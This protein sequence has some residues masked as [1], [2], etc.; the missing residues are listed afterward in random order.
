MQSRL[1][2]GIREFRSAE[3]VLADWQSSSSGD[4]HLAL[5]APDSGAAPVFREVQLRGRSYVAG[6]VDFR[7]E[8][9]GLLYLHV[10]GVRND[11][12]GRS[13]VVHN[14]EKRA[15][16]R[17]ETYQR[18]GAPEAWNWPAVTASSRAL[19][20][21]ICRAAPAALGSRPVLPG[22][23]QASQAGLTLNPA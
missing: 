21:E 17:S 9:W 15:L 1:N 23:H 19:N 16:A 4:F 3:E 2:E 13:T 6:D 10:G 12:L 18:L 11:M 20:R 7:C 5:L 22:A 8:G 14:S